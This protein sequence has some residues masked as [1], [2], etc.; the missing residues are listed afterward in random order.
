[1]IMNLN[2]SLNYSVGEKPIRLGQPQ[3]ILAQPKNGPAKI[4]KKL[5]GPIMAGPNFWLGHNWPSQNLK[6][7]GWANYG[8]AKF[9][10]GPIDDP[11][12]SPAKMAQP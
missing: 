4:L 7:I 2:R 5:A 6:K 11:A 10:A 1:M 8:W 3:P 12:I 9:L